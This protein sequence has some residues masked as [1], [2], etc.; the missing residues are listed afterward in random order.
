MNMTAAI[1][2]FAK[3]SVREGRIPFEISLGVPNAVTLAAMQ[4]VEDMTGGKKPKCS[5][6]IDDFLK[7]Q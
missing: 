2:V 7:E 3:Q 5:G 4:E 1:N 6:S